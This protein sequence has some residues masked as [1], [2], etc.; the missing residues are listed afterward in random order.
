MVFRKILRSILIFFHLDLTRNLKYDRLTKLIMKRALHEGAN[1]IDIGCHKGEVLDLIMAYAPKGIHFAF[2]PIPYLY[3][4][5][6]ARFSNT[7]NVYPYALSD[8]EGMT[9]FQLVKNAP[10]YSGIKRRRYDISDP[11]IEEIYV[12]LNLLDNIIPKNLKID[13][14]KIDVEGGEYGVLKGARE[15][16]SNNKP[17]IIFECGLGAS[18]YYNTNPLDLFSFLDEMGLGIYTLEAFIKNDSAFC[19]S[20]FERVFKTN[21]EYYFV[22]SVLKN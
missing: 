9:S 15:I 1:C 6:K 3:T 22:A 7:V 10:A 18:D 2:E 16:I 5:L 8:D 20:E 11:Q 19:P 14:I 4:A 12:E 13:F 17:L 21:K